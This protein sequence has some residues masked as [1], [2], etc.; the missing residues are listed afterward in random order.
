MP[1]TRHF[2]E[3]LQKIAFKVSNVPKITTTK[4]GISTRTGSGVPMPATLPARP[5]V[6]PPGGM[7][8]GSSKNVPTAAGK[9]LGTAVTPL[10]KT[11][12]AAEHGGNLVR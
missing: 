5:S 8:L 1:P 7:N 10:P 3:E 4:A 9:N 2:A 11:T 6:T 12:P